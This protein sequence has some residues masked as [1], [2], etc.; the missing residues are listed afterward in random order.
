[1]YMIYLY[2]IDYIYQLHKVNIDYILSSYNFMK[3]IIINC[4]EDMYEYIVNNELLYKNNIYIGD[5]DETLLKRLTTINE[6]NNFYILNTKD[7]KTEDYSY[8]SHYKINILD[9]NMI[10]YESDHNDTIIN[11][12]DYLLG[13]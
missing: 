8:L 13:I 5:L 4:E 1:M 11:I 9:F 3:K 2:C 10:W 7:L 12:P 6:C